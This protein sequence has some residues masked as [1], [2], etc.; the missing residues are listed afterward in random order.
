M[1]FTPLFRIVVEEWAKN[2]VVDIDISPISAC[3]ND[4]DIAALDSE[5]IQDCFNILY[6]DYR[7]RGAMLSRYK[8][9]ISNVFEYAVIKGY[10]AKIPKTENRRSPHPNVYNAPDERAME[11]LL[12]DED[13]T[14]AGM[15]LRLAWKCG[16]QRNEIP[17]LL[18][19]DINFK[20]AL[21]KL[22]DRNV[23]IPKGTLQYL[24]RI[25]GINL[26]QSEYV[27]ISQRGLAPMAKESLSRIARSALNKYGLCN[28]RLADLRNDFIV[29]A[30]QKYSWEYVSYISGVDLPSIRQHYLPYLDSELIQG[31]KN[32]SLNEAAIEKIIDLEG[33]S[34][35][36]LAIYLTWQLGVPVTV[37]PILTWDH[38]DFQN[39]ELTFKDKKVPIPE[40]LLGKLK[41][42][43]TGNEFLSDYLLLTENTKKPFDY[44]YLYKSVQKALIRNGLYDLSL[45]DLYNDYLK[46]H[47]APHESKDDALLAYLMDHRFTDYETTKNALGFSSEETSLLLKSCKDSGEIIQVGLRYFLPGT[48]VSPERHHEVILNYVAKNQPV[49]S[50]ELSELLGLADRRQIFPII[51]PL[52]SSG[53]LIRKSVNK[54]VLPEKTT[55]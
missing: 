31:T 10:I 42:V 17:Y 9:F 36:G 54:Y 2:H 21:A 7:I 23:P 1:V 20:D 3:L 14:P 25:R 47:N 27:L 49:T 13:D 15:I 22:P 28:V 43:K 53:E 55:E 44:P 39:S 40:N 48:V 24:E 32:T 50:N 16:L 33:T 34:A 38:I 26:S 35:E 52:L 18:W 46:R 6:D 8:A 41:D 30:L 37:L 11:L 12:V 19:E 5:I 51:K 45:I 4:V 29:R